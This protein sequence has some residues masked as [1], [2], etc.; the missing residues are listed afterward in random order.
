MR[1]RNDERRKNLYKYICSQWEAFGRLPSYRKI[2]NNP[3]L[4][5]A[6]M[7]TIS[8]DLKLLE[9]EGFLT[10][11]DVGN[12]I[13]ERKAMKSVCGSVP[14]GMPLEAIEEKGEEVVSLLFGEGLEDLVFLTAKGYSMIDRRIFDGDTLIVRKQPQAEIND[15]VI[16]QM[17]DGET[18]CKVLQ[19][20]SN[21]KYY[22]MAANPSF[23]DIY[24]EGTWSIYGVVRKVIHTV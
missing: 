4:G 7:S 12:T 3:S 10:R 22:L 14:C 2:M 13:L 11:D 17:E 24:P 1:T 21:G 8:Q 9:S 19:K 23:P 5:Y 16:A 20:D 15:I 18:T 6:S